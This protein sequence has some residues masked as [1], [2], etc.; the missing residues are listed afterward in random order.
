MG[1]TRPFSLSVALIDRHK[2]MIRRLIEEL[3]TIPAAALEYAELH[4]RLRTLSELDLLDA[5]EE[6]ERYLQ[7]NVARRIAEES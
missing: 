6:Q 4:G 2:A 3:R 1:T 7:A 5:D